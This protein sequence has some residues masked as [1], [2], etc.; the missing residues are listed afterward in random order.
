MKSSWYS[1]SRPLLKSYWLSV[2]RPV[3]MFYVMC[4][5]SV[6]GLLLLP[7]SRKYTTF[8]YRH[9]SISVLSHYLVSWY[10]LILQ[11][12]NELKIKNKIKRY[13]IV[14]EENM[15]AKCIRGW[16]ECWRCYWQ[17]GGCR[18]GYGPHHSP[19]ISAPLASCSDIAA[20][21]VFPVAALHQISCGAS[22]S[23]SV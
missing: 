3:F 4:V 1:V 9:V 7:P 15:P 10:C 11:L 20:G 19:A 14:L 5:V 8:Q 22:H 13:S 17:A 21:G 18:D 23:S 16:S 12:L 6:V 2:S